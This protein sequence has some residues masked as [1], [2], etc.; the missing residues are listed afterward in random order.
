MCWACIHSFS[1]CGHFWNGY[2]TSHGVSAILPFAPALPVHPPRLH[3]ASNLVHALSMNILLTV[4][5]SPPASG[6][7]PSSELS[8]GSRRFRLNNGRGAGTEVRSH[9]HHS[10][11]RPN[12][13]T[14]S[15]VI[16]N[17]QLV[18]WVTSW[19]GYG[20]TG[21][22]QRYRSSAGGRSQ[23][24]TGRFTC[25]EEA[26]Q[27]ALGMWRQTRRNQIM[28][29]GET[30]KSIQIGWGVSTVDYWQPRCAHQRK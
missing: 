11:A 3:V 17:V 19:H 23:P 2:K 28:S 22:R 10:V 7:A 21:G 9:T 13:V 25:G 16:H 24:L 14:H 8:P 1:H 30:D 27:T 20:F 29:F 12:L 6:L 26:R 4:L 5:W 18:L 15:T